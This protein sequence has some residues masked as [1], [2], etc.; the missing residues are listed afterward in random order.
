[1]T[2]GAITLLFIVTLTGMTFVPE[3]VIPIM[4]WP[5][6]LGLG[7]LALVLIHSLRYRA[8]LDEDLAPLLTSV[9]SLTLAFAISFEHPRRGISFLIAFIT[10]LLTG[11][12]WSMWRAIVSR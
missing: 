8:L 1:M 2:P 6:L 12:I 11:V 10:M 7:N 4:V 3:S 5:L 9:F